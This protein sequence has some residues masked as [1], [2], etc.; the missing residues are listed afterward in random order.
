MSEQPFTK[1]K[2]PPAP[3]TTLVDVLG[4]G[5]CGGPLSTLLTHAAAEE[6]ENDEEDERAT[7]GHEQDLP[8]LKRTRLCT[9]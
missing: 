4:D 7:E 2:Q 1:A 3:I 6:H 8:P 5:K 9:C